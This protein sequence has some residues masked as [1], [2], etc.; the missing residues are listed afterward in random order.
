MSVAEDVAAAVSRDEFERRHD[1]I[2]REEIEDLSPQSASLSDRPDTGRR[3]PRLPA[4][5]RRLRPAAAGRA[6]G[7]LQ[8]PGRAAHGARRW[9]SSRWSRT[10]T[11]AAAGTSPRGR[12]SSSTSCRLR[13]VADA[14]APAG[15]RRSH[16]PRGLLQHRA[17][18]DRLPAGPA[19]AATEVFD[20]R[21][22]AQKLAYAFLRKDLTG[23]L[24]RKFKIA[25]DGCADGD[26]I[27]G[28][29][30]DIGAARGG[31]RRPP[32]LPH[33]DRRRPGRRCPS[34]RGCSTSSS[35]T[36]GCIRTL[37]GRDPRLQPVRQPQEPQHGAAEVR[38]AR[39]RHRVDE[40]ADGARVRR[41]PRAAA[42]SPG[43]SSCRRASAA[44]SP[45]PPPLGPGALL[46]VVD[47]QRLRRR[48]LRRVAARAT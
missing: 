17:Q 40:G 23:N 48:R 16:Q 33:R 19:S 9:S 18:R 2:V 32:R 25:F 22:Y 38:D 35:P 7:P 46:P 6:D 30:N 28:A 14:H 11:P 15:G 43:R 26:C 24:P 41:H 34:K 42:A 44:T 31:A 20:V 29:I 3:V 8:D 13:D 37:R 5:T 10:A 1:A 39:T 27:A 47:T 36:N 4:E 12:T 45:Q 21:P